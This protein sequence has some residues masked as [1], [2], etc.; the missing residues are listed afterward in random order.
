MRLRYLFL[1]LTIA[2]GSGSSLCQ[3]CSAWESQKSIDGSSMTFHLDPYPWKVTADL[4]A[5]VTIEN[6]AKKSS[7]KTKLESVISVYLGRGNRIYFRS[8]DISSDELFTLDGFSCKE[9][10][11]VKQLDGKAEA[12]TTRT[13]RLLG[14]C[15]RQK[16]K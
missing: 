12:K 13:L 6:T 16:E 14:I 2:L 4:D 15:N 9:V 8:S 11:S 3:S 1:F 10:R 7:C 5:N